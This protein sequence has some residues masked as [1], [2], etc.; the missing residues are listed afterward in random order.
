[1]RPASAEERGAAALHEALGRVEDAAAEREPALGADR[2]GG[3]AGSASATLV[4]KKSP[5]VPFAARSCAS[6]V[7]A[8]ASRRKAHAEPLSNTTAMSSE[9]VP[10]R[11]EI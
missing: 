1:M 9:F 10:T 4:P 8:P 5:A 6:A 7:H 2:A 3:A 11:S